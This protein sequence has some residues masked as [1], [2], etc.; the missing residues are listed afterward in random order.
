[1]KKFPLYVTVKTPTGNN[2]VINIKNLP[3]VSSHINRQHL[4]DHLQKQAISIKSGSKYE[5][6]DIVLGNEVFSVLQKEVFSKQQSFFR[7]AILVSDGNL[8]LMRFVN[9]KL[10]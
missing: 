7:D 3:T 8:I 5:I 9:E 1:M 2:T 6:L 4:L 10:H